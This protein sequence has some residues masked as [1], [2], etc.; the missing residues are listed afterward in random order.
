MYTVLFPISPITDNR[1]IIFGILSNMFIKKVGAIDSIT[2]TN[3]N[4]HPACPVSC[5]E[6]KLFQYA[7]RTNI[8]YIIPLVTNEIISFFNSE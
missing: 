8:T 6:I 5:N 1:L 3:P 4:F 2:N 7:L